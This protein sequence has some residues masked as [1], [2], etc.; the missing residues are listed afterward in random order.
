MNSNEKAVAI[1]TS[2]GF[3]QK[4]LFNL[5]DNIDYGSITLT[6]EGVTTTFRGS[7]RPEYTASVRIVS[8]KV[9]GMVLAQ[10]SIGAAQAYIDGLW[11]TD[12]LNK[13]LFIFSKN[14]VLFEQIETPLAKAINVLRAMAQRLLPN[15]V[16]IAKKNILEHYD[17]GNEFFKLFLDATMMYSSAVYNAEHE[18]LEDASR[19]KLKM[20]CEKLALQPTDHLLEIGTG[21]GGFAIYAAQQYGCRVTTTT[22]SDKQYDYVKNEIARLG[23]Q[24]QITLLNCDYRQLHGQYDKLVSIEMIEAVGYQYF[25]TFFRQCNHL[26]K[27]NGLFLLQAIVINDQQYDKA[28]HEIDFIKAYIFPGGCL[29]SIDRISRSIASQTRLQLVKLEDI[30]MHYVWTLRDWSARFTN[31]LSNIRQQGFEDAFIRKWEYYFAYCAAGFSVRHVSAIHAVWCK[32][33]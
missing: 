30:G 8:P 4:C 23:L 5:L 1:R 14:A 20:I 13:L 31:N 19:R 29:P 9:Y 3:A 21:W 22:I 25:D 28:I 17:L 12:D 10:G 15:N 32:Q 6:T 26:L 27:P 18:A 24:D 16:K 11:E 2:R 7:L 33:A